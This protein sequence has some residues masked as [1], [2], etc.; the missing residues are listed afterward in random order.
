[1]KFEAYNR[2]HEN[3]HQKLTSAI[4]VRHGHHP[5]PNHNKNENRNSDIVD[6]FIF[7]MTSSKTSNYSLDLDS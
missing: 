5:T 2:K 4:D 3:I 6:F 1:M 7:F